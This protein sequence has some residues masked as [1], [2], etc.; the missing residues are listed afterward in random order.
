MEEY[1]K[2]AEP[3]GSKLI[4]AEKNFEVSSATIRN[5]MA[6]LEREG[7]ILQ[8]HT[9][10]GRVPT[11]KGY[12]YYIDNFLAGEKLSIKERNDLEK[13]AAGESRESLKNLAKELA[14]I[15]GLG[16]MVA[17]SKQ[18]VYYTGLFKFICPAGIL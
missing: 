11:E 16:V 10:A 1:T 7:L 4:A 6:E 9:S 3:V 8:P 18:D 14:E 15:S 17:F 2:T 12:Q 5:E 13:A